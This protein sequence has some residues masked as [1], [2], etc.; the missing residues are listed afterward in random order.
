MECSKA[1]IVDGAIRAT[2]TR[3]RAAPASGMPCSTP[4]RTCGF[5]NW[6]GKAPTRRGGSANGF[7]PTL[8]E[9]I[10]KRASSSTR[11]P[12]IPMERWAASSISAGRKTSVG[13]SGRR[14]TA[15][16][17]AR[18]TRSARNM[19]RAKTA[20][21]PPQP[22]MRAAWSPRPPA[23]G[24]TVTSTEPCW[25]R[26][27]TEG[28]PR[29]SRGCDMERLLEA[30]TDVVR[31]VSPEKVRAL[32]GAI[33]KIEDAKTNVS[34]SDVVGTATARAVVDRSALADSAAIQVAR[35]VLQVGRLCTGRFGQVVPAAQTDCIQRMGQGRESRRLRCIEDT[36]L[37]GQAAPGVWRQAIEVAWL[38]RA[39]KALGVDMQ[40]DRLQRRGAEQGAQERQATVLV[41]IVQP[42]SGGGA[43]KIMQQVAQVMQQSGR[44]Q[45]AVGTGAPG[46]RRGLQRVFEL[47]HR[48]AVVSGMA[49][50]AQEVEEVCNGGV[51]GGPFVKSFRRQCFGD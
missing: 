31:P 46:P 14:W 12:P 35:E 2:S 42:L 26:P 39:Q 15:R 23:S 30:V 21:S 4:S 18:P 40:P 29:S 41:Q 25:C 37:Q 51:H 5:G 3:T 50:G 6:R 7:T 28:M 11:Q 34:L 13:C 27:S 8:R 17:S 22:A 45:R 24:A 48:L 32:A 9:R 20:H 49:L 43:V 10:R 33:R 1:A 36:A 16:R 44:D 47:C 19:T 38:A